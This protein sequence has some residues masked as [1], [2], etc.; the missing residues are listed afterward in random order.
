MHFLSN[1]FIGSKEFLVIR[2]SSIAWLF[3]KFLSYKIWLS[4]RNFP[5]IPVVDITPK[6]PD[7][8]HLV[9]FILSITAII[10]VLIFPQKRYLILAVILFE[11]ASCLIDMMRWQPW[12]YQYL[13]TFIFFYYY[14]RSR[15]FLTVMSFLVAVTYLFSGL[16]KF[17]NTFLTDFWDGIL[18]H[19][20]RLSPNVVAMDIVHY[21]GLIMAIAETSIGIGLFV[22]RKKRNF[23]YLC[24]IMHIGLLLLLGPIGLNFNPVVWS[25][26]LAMPLIVWVLFYDGSIQVTIS[27]FKT[28]FNRIVFV[29][30]GLLPILNFTGYW[31]DYLSFN[32]YAG[33]AEK[34]MICFDDNKMNKEL[35]VY[36]FPP[37]CGKNSI[38]VS[39]NK[40]CFFELGVP[41]YPEERAYKKFK[42]QWDKKYPG[43]EN[44]FMIYDYPYEQNDV[45]GIQ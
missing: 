31:D 20:F 2:I 33:G 22:F 10:S 27:F 41:L 16:H 9:L 26:N 36:K 42:S 34:V 12:E 5:I 8:F 23:V 29:V 35:E 6:F 15:D 4:T 7:T 37:Y 25:W 43:H 17:S 28:A 13:L 11:I 32:L 1:L 45:R 18:E 14:N 19:L 44:T 40:W 38:T 24:V 30:I 39:V 3:A 21:S